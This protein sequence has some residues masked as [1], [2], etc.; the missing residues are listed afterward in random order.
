[1]TTIPV[2]WNDFCSILIRPISI[3][4]IFRKYHC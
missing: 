1:M 2:N 4:K 3:K